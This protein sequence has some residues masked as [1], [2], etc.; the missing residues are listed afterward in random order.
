MF[1]EDRKLGDKV[2]FNVSF[3]E[4]QTIVAKWDG[5]LEIISHDDDAI[6]QIIVPSKKL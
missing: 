4:F 3:Q 2:G 1:V 5:K 6:I